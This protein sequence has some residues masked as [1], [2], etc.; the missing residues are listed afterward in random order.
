MKIKKYVVN[1]AATG[2]V[3]P[4]HFL[5]W[6][7][8]PFAV[9]FQVDVNVGS[10]ATYVVE[11]G[12][13]DMVPKR[14]QLA[15]AT[16]VGT[17]TY[18]DHGMA[19]AG[20]K[21]GPDS[22]ILSDCWVQS[23]TALTRVPTL[24]GTFPVASVTNKDVFTFTVSDSATR[25]LAHPPRAMFVKAMEHDSYNTPSAVSTDGNL[26]F[27]VQAVRVRIASGSAGA[28]TFTVSQG[29]N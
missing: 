20:T 16:T 4:W 23:T 9:S 10:T 21:V 19:A 13:C 8:N 5:D 3:S 29:S 22:I 12:Y 14:I 15:Q 25:V 6:R 1:T 7:Q 26:A 18:P 24:E 28:L 11:Y 27:S 2:T 17:V